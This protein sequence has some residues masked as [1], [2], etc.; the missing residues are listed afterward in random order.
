MEVTLSF[1]ENTRSPAPGV[2][3]GNPGSSR[4]DTVVT[5][6]PLLSVTW[7]GVATRQSWTHVRYL[8][9]KI[10]LNV[11]FQSLHKRSRARPRKVE[12]G[13]HS[14]GTEGNY[15]QSLT[16]PPS[17]H[18]VWKR[19]SPSWGSALSPVGC[20]AHMQACSEQGRV[21]LFYGGATRSV[22]LRRLQ[23]EVR[24]YD[25]APLRAVHQE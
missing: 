23:S 25:C 22:R 18:I 20:W 3:T 1:L 21:L 17:P 13:P 9:D 15:Q 10:L 5:P 2:G 8:W 11:L 24:V 7:R 16:E 19:H 6:A 14:N 4:G 12:Q